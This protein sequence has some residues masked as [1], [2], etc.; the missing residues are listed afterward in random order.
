M[1]TG[2][3]RLVRKTVPRK[4]VRAFGIKKYPGSLKPLREVSQQNKWSG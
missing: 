2:A 1:V 4:F 3:S